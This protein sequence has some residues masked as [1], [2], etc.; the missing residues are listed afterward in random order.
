MPKSTIGTYQVPPSE[1]PKS[2]V[3]KKMV[4]G[5][6]AGL[7]AFALWANYD[8]QPG[9]D[10][11]HSHPEVLEE[12]DYDFWETFPKLAQDFGPPGTPQSGGYVP[13][14]S[15]VVNTLM[16]C[17]LE[18]EPID[19]RTQRYQDDDEVILWYG[20]KLEPQGWVM[21]A[22]LYKPFDGGDQRLVECFTPYGGDATINEIDRA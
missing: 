16:K 9:W 4:A 19:Y 18:M 17:S 11:Y 6:V 20:M 2:K 5:V 22:S 10:E 12:S 3:N 8:N 14:D 21:T 7:V 15:R 13:D 1:K